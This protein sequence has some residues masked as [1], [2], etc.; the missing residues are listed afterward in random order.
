MEQGKFKVWS[1]KIV[2][3]CYDCGSD[4]S[5]M[6]E[7]PMESMELTSEEFDLFVEGVRSN[8]GRSNMVYLYRA[9][10][11]DDVST[12]RSMIESGHE[13]RKQRAEKQAQGAAKKAARELKIAKEKQQE[14]Q[15]VL[16][17]EKKLYEELRSKFEKDKVG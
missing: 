12:I 5:T 11:V 2:H 10:Y 1:F 8:K 17:K 16:E 6:F 7:F 15:K 13:L 3:N 14:A 9:P 4:S